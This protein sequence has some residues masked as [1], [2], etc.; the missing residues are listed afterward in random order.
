MSLSLKSKTT[1]YVDI[2]SKVLKNIFKLYADYFLKKYS[3]TIIKENINKPD[4]KSAKFTFEAGQELINVFSNF[5]KNKQ[6]NASILLSCYLCEGRL[7]SFSYHL[8]NS[9]SDEKV[10][11]MPLLPFF[12]SY[13]IEKAILLMLSKKNYFKFEPRI[14]V[15]RFIISL[16]FYIKCYNEILFSIRGFIALSLS[17]WFKRKKM[18]VSEKNP[19]IWMGVSATEMHQS[20]DFL[21]LPN[22]L[23]KLYQYSFDLNNG[24]S[25]ID[26]LYIVSPINWKN[27]NSN[28]I[29]FISSILNINTKFI[30]FFYLKIFIR[31]L[32]FIK[33]FLFF[34]FISFD[35]KINLSSDI[36]SLHYEYIFKVVN[37]RALIITY[38]FLWSAAPHKAML[39]LKRPVIL[40]YYSSPTAALPINFSENYIYYYTKYGLYSHAL[41]WNNDIASRA[42]QDDLVRIENIRVPGAIMFCTSPPIKFEDYICYKEIHL[43]MINKFVIS[44]FDLTPFSDSAIFRLDEA[45]WL[46]NYEYIK[47]FFEDIIATCQKLFANNFIILIK[48]KRSLNNEIHDMRY[49]DY[50]EKLLKTIPN[51]IIR[52]EPNSNPWHVICTSHLTISIPFTST[53]QAAKFVGIPSCFYSPTKVVKSIDN[54]LPEILYG[55]EELEKFITKYK[56]FDEKSSEEIEFY[57]HKVESVVKNIASNINEFIFEEKNS[58]DAK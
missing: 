7:S 20:N 2:E 57:H 36:E 23:D 19:I 52:Y 39:R 14:I 37:F 28:P 29:H 40:L 21:S 4:F 38:S 49:F 44:L 56:K 9:N 16:G 34:P 54:G 35:K 42:I 17:L 46:Y 15:A 53:S 32:F 8:S 50:L 26:G 10:H 3:I 43:K 5:K 13:K 6:N 12:I 24:K 48:P 22:F 45:C 1:L 33:D 41:I 58:Q 51:N 18:I 30:F 47:S 25:T 27:R 31:F 55:K 11:F